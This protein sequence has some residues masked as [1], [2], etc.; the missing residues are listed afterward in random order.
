MTSLGNTYFGNTGSGASGSI[1]FNHN[2]GTLVVSIST[3]SDTKHITGMTFNG[4]AM[5]VFSATMQ[6]ATCYMHNAPQGTYS[7][8]W[9]ADGDILGGRWMVASI[10]QGGDFAQGA[11]AAGAFT[12][13]SNTSFVWSVCNSHG[14]VAHT[15]TGTAG[16]VELDDSSDGYYDSS[17]AYWQNGNGGAFTSS[18]SGSIDRYHYLEFRSKPGGSPMW[19]L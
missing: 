16:G 17:A 18:I 14:T 9:A 4:V 8:A 13:V 12:S 11:T 15:W 5:T 10:V 2:G 19:W 1:N 7:L 6:L 3:S